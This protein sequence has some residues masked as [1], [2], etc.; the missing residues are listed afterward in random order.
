MIFHYIIIFLSLVCSRA[1]DDGFI[2]LFLVLSVFSTSTSD[3]DAIGIWLE[4]LGQK[5]FCQHHHDLYLTVHC[6]RSV[7]V[8]SSFFEPGVEARQLNATI[9]IPARVC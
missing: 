6:L 5:G 2:C 9:R 4:V 1:I 3:F 8:C 7:F